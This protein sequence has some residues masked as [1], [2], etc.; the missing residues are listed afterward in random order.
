MQTIVTDVRCV[1][2]SV[3]QS[4]TRLNSASLCGGHSV[5]YLPNHF[6]VLTFFAFRYRYLFYFWWTFYLDILFCCQNS[7][8]RQ[9]AKTRFRND[10]TMCRV[11]RKPLVT[12]NSHLSG[13]G[14]SCVVATGTKND[15]DVAS[16][17]ERER[18]ID[19]DADV[20]PWISIPAHV[21]PVR[22]SLP[23]TDTCTTYT[24]DAEFLARNNLVFG[25]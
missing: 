6:G 15:V 4:V 8:K 1:Y 25:V 24:P 2:L 18:F 22:I 7:C 12:D 13:N 20:A 9:P 3:C 19:C 16:S 14:R 21:P 23:I 11:G 17:V 5:Q 10:L